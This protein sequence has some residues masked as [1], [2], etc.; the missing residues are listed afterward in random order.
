MEA[1]KQDINSNSHSIK[2][3]SLWSNHS[4]LLLWLGSSLSHIGFQ[5]YTIVIPLVIYEMTQS[6]LA[7]SGMRIIEFLPNVLLGMVAGVLVDRMNRK[8]MLWITAIVQWISIGSIL[9]LLMTQLIELWSLFLLGFILSTSS[10]VKGNATHTI[11]PQLVTREQLT[12]ANSKMSFTDTLIRTIGP[13]VAGMILAVTSFSGTFAIQFVCATFV[14][15]T[16]GF[17]KATPTPTHDS[18]NSFLNDIKEGIRELFQ[19]K[20]LLTPTIVILFQNF[21]SSMVLGVL[22]FFTVDHIGASE[23]EVGLML[24]LAGIGG[25]LGAIVIKKLSFSF[26]RGKIYTYTLVGEII[27]YGILLIAQVWW[28][29]GLSLAIRTFA[30]TI[31]NILYFSIRQEF[32][33]NHLLG[34]VA[35]TS[36]MIMKSATPIGLLAAGIWAEYLPI[37]VLFLFTI[38]ISI[39]L[40]GVLLQTKFFKTLK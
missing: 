33:P 10:Y 17:L 8:N 40:F 19:N 4:F 12:D 31:S 39:T 24:S 25:L 37:R 2:A 22:I 5:M 9:G 34:R 16:I 1:R 27:G 30:I 13:G 26:A 21:A 11:L 7:M 20:I 32:T 35:G 28:M 14:I 38:C 6:P 23:V 36:S 18:A 29:I 3:K 15:I